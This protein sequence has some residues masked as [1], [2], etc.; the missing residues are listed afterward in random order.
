MSLIN[1]NII[2]NKLSKIR[3]NYPEIHT[4]IDAFYIFG[5]S[6]ILD[7]SEEDA[8]ES[9]TDNN[10]L[11]IHKPWK[12]GHDRWIDAIYIEENWDKEVTIH[13][14]NFKYTDKYEKIKSH[15]PW[16]EINIL[17]SI[18][19]WIINQDKS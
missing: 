5:L 6:T 11:S 8:M 4:N 10:F 17:E 9:I 12:S 7:I 19:N 18:I 1:F 3:D 15:F 16:S 14:F 13:L 2:G